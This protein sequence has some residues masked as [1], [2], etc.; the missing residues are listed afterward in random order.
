MT[1]TRRVRVTSDES[2]L[3]SLEPWWSHPHPLRRTPC[4]RRPRLTVR[5][6]DLLC[7][8]CRFR[9]DLDPVV[10]NLDVVLA[11]Q[12]EACGSQPLYSTRPLQQMLPRHR[13]WT[14]VLQPQIVAIA[15]VA[16]RYNVQKW[17]MPRCTL[18]CVQ[19]GIRELRLPHS[20]KRVDDLL[21]LLV[22]S[23]VRQSRPPL[24]LDFHQD[25]LIGC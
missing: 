23:K 12:A 5:F 3:H 7:C 1:R 15:L 11:A 16:K 2:R 9:I 14:H 19:A 4:E 18:R 22:V 8:L 6:E 25:L 24:V 13:E 20:T 21:P 17:R 10:R